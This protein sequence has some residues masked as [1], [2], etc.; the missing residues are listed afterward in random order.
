L[1][2]DEASAADA[3]T[4]DRDCAKSQSPVGGS[5]S[6]LRLVFDIRKLVRIVSPDTEAIL[7]RP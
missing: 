2:T 6:A 4:T 7:S 1:D 3:A 5:P